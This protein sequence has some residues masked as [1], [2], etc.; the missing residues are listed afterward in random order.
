MIAKLN[1]TPGQGVYNN[2][3]HHMFKS[4]IFER[5]TGNLTHFPSV[6]YVIRCVSLANVMEVLVTILKNYGGVVLGDNPWILEL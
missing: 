5:Q 2:Q 6:I 4:T 1:K 3:F